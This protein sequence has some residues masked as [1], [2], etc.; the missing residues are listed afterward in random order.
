MNH[1]VDPSRKTIQDSEA[2][3][4]NHGK[5]KDGGLYVNGEIKLMSLHVPII[6]EL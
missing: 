4:V 5:Y 3:K 6:T 2:F 1:Y